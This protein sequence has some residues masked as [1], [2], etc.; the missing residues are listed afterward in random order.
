M[1]AITAI[2]IPGMGVMFAAAKFAFPAAAFFLAFAAFLFLA[3]SDP[4]EVSVPAIASAFG[5]GEALGWRKEQSCPFEQLPCLKN[6]QLG[7]W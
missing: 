1:V 7:V 2:A 3:F 6:L 4:S 5:L